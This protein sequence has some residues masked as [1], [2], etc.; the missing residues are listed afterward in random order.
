MYASNVF[1]IKV[2]NNKLSNAITGSAGVRQGNN[3]S[4][5]NFDIFFNDVVDIFDKDLSDHYKLGSRHF[6]STLC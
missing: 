1:H 5:T 3:L 6:N 2:G 4:Q